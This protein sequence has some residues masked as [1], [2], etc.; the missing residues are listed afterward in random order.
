M[1]IMM[2]VFPISMSQIKPIKLTTFVLSLVYILIFDNIY[3][4][5]YLLKI[6]HRWKQQQHLI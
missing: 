2:T 3:Q 4:L 5:T 1:K 6:L